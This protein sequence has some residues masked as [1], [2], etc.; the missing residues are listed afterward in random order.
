MGRERE[1]Q[2]DATVSMEPIVELFTTTLRPQPEPKARIGHLTSCATQV[3]LFIS[4]I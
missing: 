4:L 1:S 2:A 3:P